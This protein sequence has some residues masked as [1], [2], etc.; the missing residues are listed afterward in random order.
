[1]TVHSVGSKAA[2]KHP[3]SHPPLQCEVQHVPALEKTQCLMWYNQQEGRY[4]TRDVD[5]VESGLY[6]S[7]TAPILLSQEALSKP[8]NS[9][10]VRQRAR[11]TGGELLPQQRSGGLDIPRGGYFPAVKADIP[12]IPSRV[13]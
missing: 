10:T 6:P 4:G 8:V 7:L 5:G 9:N 2:S 13:V 12:M 1:M 11:E 3:A